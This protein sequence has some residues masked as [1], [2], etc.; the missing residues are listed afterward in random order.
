MPVSS[1]LLVERVRSSEISAKVNSSCRT[2]RRRLNNNIS[3][4]AQ[5]KASITWSLGDAIRAEL[6]GGLKLKEGSF[7]MDESFASL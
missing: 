4:E 5:D 7:L 6:G 3:A 2:K 1:S